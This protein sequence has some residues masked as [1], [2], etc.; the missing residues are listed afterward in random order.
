MRI[1]KLYLLLVV[2]LVAGYLW[3]NG[4]ISN[5]SIGGQKSYSF[6]DVRIDALVQP[7]GSMIIQERRTADFSGSF[8]RMYLDIPTKGFK[9]LSDIEVSEAGRP[10][11]L[12]K[13]TQAR[14]DGHYAFWL[15]DNNYHIEWYFQARDSKRTFDVSYRVADCVKLHDDV[16]ELYWKFIGEMWDVP[17]KNVSVNLTLP[18]G[19]KQGEVLAWGHGP[20]QGQ[21]EIPSSTEVIWRVKNLPERRFLEGRAVFPRQLVAQGKASTGTRALPSILAEEQQWQAKADAE[22]L[23][24]RLILLGGFLLSFLILLAIPQLTA[25]I[26]WRKEREGLIPLLP[27]LKQ[28]ITAPGKPLMKRCCSRMRNILI[29]KMPGSVFCGGCGQTIKR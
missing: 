20:L 12:T 5:W 27:K 21:V 22:R 19:A 25:G 11:S 7:D 14:T 24:S 4:P 26:R 2:V 18:G 1:N 6:D 23:K 29:L 17:T 16:A 28:L 10:Y 15:K 3:N 8:T 9:E 13:N